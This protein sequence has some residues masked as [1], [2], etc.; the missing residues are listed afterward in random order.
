MADIGK[1]SA[2]RHAWIHLKQKQSIF[3]LSEKCLYEIK[4]H[5]SAVSRRGNF[6]V[7]TGDS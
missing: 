3:K 2:N 7:N 6:V 5:R 4:P 1:T